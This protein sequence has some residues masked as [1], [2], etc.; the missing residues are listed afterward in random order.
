MGVLQQILITIVAIALAALFYVIRRYIKITRQQRTTLENINKELAGARDEAL[1]ATRAKSV[2]LANMSHELRTPMNAIIGYSEM[3]I[4]DAEED[5]QERYIA[6]LKKI[7]TAGKHLLQLINDILDLSKI[8]A[9]KL[10]LYLETFDVGT[11]IQDVSTTIQPLAEKNG[12]NI[13]IN[14]AAE[15]GLMRADLTRVR[16]I[17]FNLLS[18]ACKFTDH[19]T[20]SLTTT[21]EKRNGEDWF[22]ISVKDSG[23]G[24]TEEQ[25]GKLF[26]PFSQA[27]SSTTRKYGGTGLGLAITR[28]FCEMMGGNISVQSQIGNGSTFIVQL[29]AEV[30][31]QQ[32]GKTDSVIKSIEPKSGEACTVLSIDDDPTIHDLLTRF[33]NKEGFKVEVALSGEE[34]IR[35]AKKLHPQVILLDVLMPN[36][37]GWAVLSALK[38]DGD[39]ATIPV[40]MMTIVDDKNLGF[41]LGASDYICKPVDWNHLLTMVKKYRGIQVP[42]SALVV[43]DDADSREMLSRVLVKDG[44]SVD[45]AENGRVALKSI[46]QHRPDIILLDLMMPDID[47][48]EFLA[49]LREREQW[50]S[51]PVIVV[52]G[53]DLT[54]EDHM[55]LNSNVA[56]IVKK[57]SFNRQSLLNEVKEQIK[58][59]LDRKN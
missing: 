25:I 3:L 22:T 48:F 31:E 52:T 37:D 45:E 24:M 51:I 39:I 34:G 17:L 41:T 50:R 18:N 7:H 54:E 4:E 5:G 8:E 42:S 49:K 46:S 12:N 27:D 40:I 11:M 59:C 13:V 23:I 36:M 35:L 10:E 56:R 20:V 9:N 53:K 32:A 28:R 55:K 30:I 21:R 26:Q 33:L 6:D 58:I 14:S 47:G 19:G 15:L 2:F 16:Q 43:E 44:W 57:G 1:D 38:S 29:P